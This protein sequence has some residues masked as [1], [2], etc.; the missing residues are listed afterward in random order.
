MPNS[1]CDHRNVGSVNQLWVNLKP[2]AIS[3]LLVSS[4]AYNL[5]F[6]E[7]SAKIRKVVRLSLLRMVFVGWKTVVV[8]SKKTREY[9]EVSLKTYSN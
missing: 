9:F 6:V 8:D 5:M 2:N 3:L 1:Y 4:I 7:I